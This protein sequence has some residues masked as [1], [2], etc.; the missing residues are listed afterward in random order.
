MKRE[1]NGPKAPHPFCVLEVDHLDQL[2]HPSGKPGVGM[3]M[4]NADQSLTDCLDSYSA[5]LEFRHI[6][7]C[8]CKGGVIHDQIT[9]GAALFSGLDLW[10]MCVLV[11]TDAFEASYVF[12]ITCLISHLIKF[13]IIK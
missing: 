13:L 3:F 10:I 8:P 6:F 4:E 7:P 1:S 2:H 11:I 9:V 5:S 12:D